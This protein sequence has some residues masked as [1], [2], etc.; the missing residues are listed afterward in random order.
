MPHWQQCASDDAAVRSAPL[1]ISKFIDNKTGICRLCGYGLGKRFMR[2]WR[3]FHESDTQHH[4]AYARYTNEFTRLVEERLIAQWERAQRETVRHQ[5]ADI[6]ASV[7][8]YDVMRWLRYGDE[9]TIAVKAALFDFIFGIDTEIPRIASA[10]SPDDAQKS[11][12][13]KRTVCNLR[14]SKS[15]LSRILIYRYFTHL[16]G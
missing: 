15:I 4:A 2:D 8:G 14:H 9:S 6:V 10:K 16:S 13:R 7:R 12:V 3:K 11:I 1:G 5:D